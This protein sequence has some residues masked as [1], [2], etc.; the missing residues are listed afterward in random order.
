[1]LHNG[2]GNG[3]LPGRFRLSATAAE[4]PELPLSEALRIA[5]ADKNPGANAVLRAAFD[6]YTSG[7]SHWREIRALERRRK[8]LQDHATLCHVA[9]AVPEPR[10]MRVLA[11]GNWMDDSGAVVEPTTPRFLN[12]LGVQGR[13]A[14]R[15]DLANWLVS[16]DNPLTARVYVNRAWKMFFGTGLSKVLDDVGSQ[17]EPPVN[18][19]LLDWLAVEFMESGWDVKRLVRTLLLSETYRRSSNPSPELHEKDP[20]NR[21]H[22][23]QTIVRLPAEMI[24]DSALRISGLLNPRVGGPS[25]K[26]YQ[27]AGY[28]Q[29][30]NFPK[31]EYEPDYNPRQFRR[32]LYTHWQRTFLH[33][34]LMAFD[35][36]SREECTA[37]R[38]VSNTPLQSLALLNDPTYVEAARAF[39]ARILAAKAADRFDW[40]FRE[41]FARPA[42]EEE[43]AI[44]TGL[45]DRAR[46]RFHRD[47]A[48]AD[49]LLA[50]GI[51]PNPAKADEA[52]LAAWTSVARALLNKHELVMRY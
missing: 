14:T 1:M 4:F 10:E 37:E 7:N 52:E 2:R 23:R 32:G 51:A 47:Q 27:P 35:A 41:A 21:L 39:A 29:E 9:K 46:S 19:E 44:L 5:A 6:S 26:P 31:R 36:P 43:K 38:T 40:A 45:L 42:T 15:L 16:R 50:T 3:T 34:S 22:G 48:A 49:E 25:V 13:R 11:R 30:L 24:R 28:Y 17:G 8:T 33:P 12:P 20:F 18:P